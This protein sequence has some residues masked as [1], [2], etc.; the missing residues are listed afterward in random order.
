M[1]GLVGLPLELLRAVLDRLPRGDQAALAC[2]CRALRDAAA[3]R[4]SSQ[5]QR[6]PAAL[7]HPLMPWRELAR[8]HLLPCDLY[9]LLSVAAELNRSQLAE[10]V[11]AAGVQCDCPWFCRCEL[12]PLLA[13]P[14]E[15]VFCVHRIEQYAA[16]TRRVVAMAPRRCNLCYGP[17]RASMAR[18]DVLV[19]HKELVGWDGGTTHAY[20]T[21]VGHRGQW[22]ALVEYWHG[23]N[24]RIERL[25]H[26]SYA[27]FQVS[28]YGRM[29]CCRTRSPRHRLPALERMRQRNEWVQQQLA[30]SP[31]E[32]ELPWTAQLRALL[33]AWPGTAADYLSSV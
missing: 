25:L 13:A 27:G 1:T 28:R 19:H 30:R 3:L 7:R 11:E 14:S 4:S 5:T 9:A 31:P 17:S 23:R 2:T 18:T 26:V 20:R 29:L 21:V 32:S 12:G 6:V 10:A 15:W 16:C 8:E 33:A 22:H 24:N